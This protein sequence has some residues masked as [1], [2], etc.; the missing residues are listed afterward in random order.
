MTIEK[1]NF[2][3]TTFRGREADACREMKSLLSELGDDSPRVEISEVSGLIFGLTKLDPISVPQLLS[4]IVNSDPWKVH[5]IQ[6]YIPIQEVT[7]TSIDS[8]VDAAKKLSGLIGKKERFK[9][10]IEKRHSEID[11][12]ELIEKVAALFSQK[13]DL[14]NP[15]KIVLIEIVGKVAGLSIIKP[16]D[17][18][19]SVI[20]KRKG[21]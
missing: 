9:V 12:K 2:I 10:M 8:I 15:D 5:L 6:R 18:F 13:V 4:K 11:S 7:E 20:T 16:Q 19:S 17:I 21:I 1:P 14:E 3:A